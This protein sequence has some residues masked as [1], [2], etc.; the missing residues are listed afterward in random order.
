M[1]ENNYTIKLDT[2]ELFPIDWYEN[3]TNA[4]NYVLSNMDIP[5]EK[6]DDV[7]LHIIDYNIDKQ[8]NTKY[9]DSLFNDLPV[10]LSFV[11]TP[12]TRVF[13]EFKAIVD[14]CNLYKSFNE[15]TMYFQTSDFEK[16]KKTIDLWKN[17]FKKDYPNIK[18]TNREL[19]SQNCIKLVIRKK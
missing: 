7:I 5:E 12:S 17:L 1:K 2:E 14:V 9:L 11:D 10:Y 8:L 6:I 18:I 19:K 13:N 3:V 16:D 4:A 15:H